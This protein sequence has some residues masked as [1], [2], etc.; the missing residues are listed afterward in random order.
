MNSPHCAAS[1]TVLP[2]VKCEEV[3]VGHPF[4]Q[5]AQ[6]KIHISL[7]IGAHTFNPRPGESEAGESLSARP[8]W[9]QDKV[10]GQPELHSKTLSQNVHARTHTHKHTSYFS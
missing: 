7:D 6:K 5:V 2:R 9:L 4:L 1:M 10:A 3:P 8:V